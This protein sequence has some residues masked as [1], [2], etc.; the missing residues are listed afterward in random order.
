M[1]EL[2]VND[3]RPALAKDEDGPRRDGQSFSAPASSQIHSKVV[4]VARG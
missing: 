4:R 2:L 1:L 3:E